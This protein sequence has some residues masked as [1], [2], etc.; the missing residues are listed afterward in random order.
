GAVD[1][2]DPAHRVHGEVWALDD[3]ERGLAWLDDYEG[4]GPGRGASG[5]YQRLERL[6][7]LATSTE[8]AAWVYLYQ[9][10]VMRLPVISDG[11]WRVARA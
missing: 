6:V 7:R 5:E 3:P 11:R 8:V 2:T 4:I 9:G 1:S 10:D